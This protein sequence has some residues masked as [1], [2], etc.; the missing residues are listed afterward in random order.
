MN[1]FAHHFSFEFRNGLRNRSLLLLNYL[2]P[3]SFYILMGLLMTQINPLFTKT[4]IPAMMVFCM[5]SATVIG[6]PNPLVE[7][8]EAGI[9]RSYKINGV[10]AF[11]I[12]TMP[13]LTTMFHTIIASAIITLTA[14]WA[15]KAPLPTNWLAFILIALLSA[16][17][18][19]ALGSLIGVISSDTRETVLWSQLIYLPSM[20]LGGLMFPSHLL[21]AGL[22]RLGRL[23]PTTYA[24]H[25]FQNLALGEEV[26]FDPL[27]SVLILL[28]SGMLAFALAIY[29]FN[30][31]S[32][33]TTP[34]GH[35][36]MALLALLPY[37]AGAILLP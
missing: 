10:P 20:M 14:P 33:N 9:F 18:G 24:M 7:A 16:F 15:F 17:V 3:L 11:S 6:L 8:R 31:D 23:L 32:R 4:M 29:L 13:A 34:R 22:A 21:P 19:A 25:A 30:W 5:L 1:A 26:G 28:A 35:R 2:F 37:A 12:L 36:L 27:W